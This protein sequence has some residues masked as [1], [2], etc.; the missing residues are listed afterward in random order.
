[1]LG[2]LVCQLWISVVVPAEVTGQVTVTAVDGA[3]STCDTASIAQA[4]A[5]IYVTAP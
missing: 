1:M 2:Q 5:P 3:Q 4:D